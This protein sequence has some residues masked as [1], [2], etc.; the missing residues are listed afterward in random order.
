MS[1][2]SWTLAALHLL[3][4]ALGAGGVWAR[5]LALRQNPRPDQLR[6][7]F[8]ADNAWGLAALLWLAT[9][10]WRA[11]GGVEKGTDYYLGNWLFLTKMA[12]FVLIF[13][14]EISPMVTF[15]RWRIQVGKGETPNTS[16]ALR[17][18]RTSFIQGILLVLMVLAAT[19]MARG[20][21]G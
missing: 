11:F 12:L 6:W 13:A 10:L 3:A 2:L 18:A 9:G 20:W 16:P 5:A 4:L 14:L 15:V 1:P 19:G 17:F 8:Y 7:V 21:G